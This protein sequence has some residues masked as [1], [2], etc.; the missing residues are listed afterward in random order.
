MAKKELTDLEWE[1]LEKVDLYEGAFENFDHIEHIGPYE[2][3]S[4][5]LK[6]VEAKRSLIDQAP[7]DWLLDK[8]CNGEILTRG[9][10]EVPIVEEDDGRSLAER[11]SIRAEREATVL[12]PGSLNKIN[13]PVLSQRVK[14]DHTKNVFFLPEETYAQVEVDK[15][16]LADQIGISPAE[17]ENAINKKRSKKDP[18]MKFWLALA[19]NIQDG[20]IVARIQVEAL[21]S[22]W[23]ETGEII[24]DERT[25]SDLVDII[26]S[27]L[28]IHM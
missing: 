13:V 10:K 25:I 5:A 8:V 3:F 6:G 1:H 22:R 11:S 7:L 26:C 17:L 28:D 24:K 21:A 12:D 19:K 2:S 16:E 27:T 14:L 9:Y 15:F 23:I 18:G 4:K 20:N